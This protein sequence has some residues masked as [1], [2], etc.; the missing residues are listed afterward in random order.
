MLWMLELPCISPHGWPHLLS[1]AKV[2]GLILSEDVSSVEPTSIVPQN[3]RYG[4]P[5][6]CAALAFRDARRQDYLHVRPLL[7]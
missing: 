1:A 6:M 3:L 5:D 4:R 2:A 7:F